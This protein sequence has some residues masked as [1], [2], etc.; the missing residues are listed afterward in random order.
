MRYY[1]EKDSKCSYIIDKELGFAIIEMTQ[2]GV[3][4]D[5]MCKKI[6]DFLNKELEANE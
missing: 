5:K 4:H 6:C 2:I 3:T 1:T